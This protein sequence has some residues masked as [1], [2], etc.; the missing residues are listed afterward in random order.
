MRRIKR[1][2]KRKAQVIYIEGD[3]VMVK[4]RDTQKD[5]KHYDL[6][7]FVVHTGSQK[8]GSNRFELQDK[9]IYWS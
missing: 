3:G 6:S 8:V 2:G 5:N 1:L 4:A 9:R 7:H